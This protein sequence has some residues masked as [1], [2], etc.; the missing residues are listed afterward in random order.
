LHNKTLKGTMNLQSNYFNVSDFMSADKTK[1]DKKTAADTSKLTVIT[2]PKNIDFTMQADFK[3]LVYEK[4]NFT[5]AKGVL[6]VANGD[7]K[8]QN[9]NVQAFGG[10][11]VVNG[12][13]GTSD[14]KKPLVNFDMAINEVVFTEVFKQVEILQKLAPIFEK[15][16]GKFS[17]KLSFN[18]LLK[19]DMMP[20][21]ASLIGNGS[22]STKSV[23]LSNV[24]ALNALA[25]GLKRADLNPM[26]I[27]DLGLLFE[28]KDG[29][30]NTKPFNFKVGD[31]KMTLGGSTGLDKSIAYAGKVQLPDKMNLGN[32]S[33]VNV[34]I[35]GTFAKPKVEIDWKNMLNTLVTDTKAKAVTEVNKQIDAAKPQAIK[36]AQDQADKLRADAKAVGDKLLAEAKAQ[37]D[38]LIAKA[39][40]PIT[41]MLAQKTAQKLL[42]EAQKKVNDLNAKADTQAKQLIQK[43]ADNAKVQ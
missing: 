2:I 14:P 16:S 42:E 34:K 36:A 10:N 25:A 28:I 19:S 39:T 21:L 15:A 6:T 13:Y 38:Q 37:G 35:G 9:M 11:M 7:M 12:L 5:N 27:K 23:G 32:F 4:M 43:A 29:K 41:K 1:P 3:K 24:P 40:N 8:I 18:S 17:T 22:F 26:S 20:D 30:V 31:V 33:T